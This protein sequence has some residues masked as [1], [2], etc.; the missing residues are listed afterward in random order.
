MDTML[1]SI[2]IWKRKAKS[3]PKKNVD[4]VSKMSKDFNLT[5]D[6]SKVSCSLL[7]SDQGIGEN[8]SG[9]DV[10]IVPASDTGNHI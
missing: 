4:Y 8:K 10:K 1:S 5:I 7:P 3:L 2:G 9:V 6:D